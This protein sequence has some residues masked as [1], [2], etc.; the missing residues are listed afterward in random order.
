[1]RELLARLENLKEISFTGRAFVTGSMGQV[2]E[3]LLNSCM[4]NMP[5]LEQMSLE[6]THIS[7]EQ[8]MALSR[9]VKAKAKRGF[10]VKVGTRGTT[11]Q[12]IQKMM[13]NI[14]LSK[15]VFSDFCDKTGLL[16]V[17]RV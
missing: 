13:T 10:T 6:N 9:A 15:Y 2:K 7:K 8:G 17:Q 1:M 16:T 14:S 3:V 5:M 4:D 11:G 12:G